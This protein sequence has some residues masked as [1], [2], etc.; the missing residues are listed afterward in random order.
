[1]SKDPEGIDLIL[2]VGDLSYAD[3]VQHRWDKW[4]RMFEYLAA[5]VPWMV[6]VGNHENEDVGSPFLAYQTRFRMP[7]MCVLFA[8]PRIF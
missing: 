7:G 4:G 2:H 1:M 6:F 5:T 8:I 3:G